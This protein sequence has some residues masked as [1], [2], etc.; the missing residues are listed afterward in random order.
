MKNEIDE[1]LVYNLSDKE[2]LVCSVCQ[3]ACYKYT[4]AD[5]KLPM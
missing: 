5:F 2:V 3:F 1:K 4:V